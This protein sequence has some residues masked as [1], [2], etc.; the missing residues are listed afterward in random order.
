ML[1]YL[2]K[3]GVVTA[4]QADK[5]RAWLIDL[6]RSARD[7]EQDHRDANLDSSDDNG[8]L[9]WTGEMSLQD[10]E[11]N[12]DAMDV[13]VQLAHL[14]QLFPALESEASSEERRRST[15]PASMAVL[16]SE[17]GDLSVE[18]VILS[19]RE[20]GSDSD[21]EVEG[22]RLDVRL[23]RS[24]RRPRNPHV[25]PILPPVKR[26]R[27]CVCERKRPA[28][29][30]GLGRCRR[31]CMEQGR[32]ACAYHRHAQLH[33]RACAVCRR[34][35]GSVGAWCNMCLSCCQ[36]H[37]ALCATHTDSA[38][39]AKS[40]FG[41]EQTLTQYIQATAHELE[42][43]HSQRRGDRALEC[44]LTLLPHVNAAPPA[45]AVVSTTAIAAHIVAGLGDVSAPTDNVWQLL[46]DWVS[47]LNVLAF[48]NPS[49][50]LNL[51]IVAS[52]WLAHHE[53]HADPV[54]VVR[55]MYRFLVRAETVPAPL[56]LLHGNLE[57]QYGAGSPQERRQRAVEVYRS[58]L[59]NPAEYDLSAGPLLHALGALEPETALQLVVQQR[60]KRPDDVALVVTHMRLLES[61]RRRRRHE[62]ADLH[63]NMV[64]LD[65]TNASSLDWL[66][67]K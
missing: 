40:M 43:A 58:A 13:D 65:P 33:L 18:Q 66:Y 60:A 19:K 16:S 29:G 50:E 41:G 61:R 62:I 51:W 11:R 6:V 48:S 8:S 35:Y 55:A 27:C 10:G 59:E 7:T 3:H 17:G 26:S 52:N 28:Q 42:L 34:S 45:G 25:H 20:D 12:V 2:V 30:C 67:A 23:R 21:P 1:A 56:A 39:R 31:C 46:H 15:I 44:V 36:H 57:A 32:A 63:L 22:D 38:V 54:A 49:S 14:S 24:K 64:R 47:R 53:M 4:L 37:N 5:N 9:E